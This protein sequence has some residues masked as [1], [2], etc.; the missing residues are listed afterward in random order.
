MVYSM[1]TGA[2]ELFAER[3]A[4]RKRG[5]AYHRA[6]LRERFPTIDIEE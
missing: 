3:F 6:I 4:L 1:G 5:H 2:R